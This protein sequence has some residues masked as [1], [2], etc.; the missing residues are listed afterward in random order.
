MKKRH[1]PYL[2]LLALLATVSYLAF[3]KT[4]KVP[5][6]TTS[7]DPEMLT[8]AKALLGS[9]TEEQRHLALFT[10]DDDGREA[11]NFVPMVRKGLVYQKMSIEQRQLCLQLLRTGLSA[12]GYVQAKGI[13]GWEKILSDL[14]GRQPG[15]NYRNPEL[16]YL[17]IFG[18]PAADKPWGWR[19]EGHHLSL[20]YTS[21]TG[22]LSVTP[23]F[24]GT[25]PAKVPSGEYAGMRLMDEEE[26]MARR[27]VL[28]F[29]GAQRRMAVISAT[30]FPEIVTG[31]DRVAALGGKKGLPYEAMLPDQ[32]ELLDMLLKV[33][34][35]RMPDDVADAK[36]RTIQREGMAQVF[37]AWAGSL[38]E[39]EG[40]YY[41]IQGK[42]FLVEYDNT[43]NDANHIHTVW[44]DFNGDFGR[45]LLREHNQDSH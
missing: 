25:N 3:T 36:W 42:S 11:W 20:N 35:G 23:Q 37:F 34:L 16:Y 41:R 18:E 27:L 6:I 8:A 10:F 44:R 9:L 22:K 43:Q 5:T 13:M 33:Y 31:T 32:Q 21:V 24:M 1:I 30:A 15:N 38:R 29:D 2:L 7:P 28:S 17:A 12:K 14:E 26:D 4:T 45:D 39:G 19:F 40:H